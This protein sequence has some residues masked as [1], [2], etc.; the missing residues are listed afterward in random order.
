[1]ARLLILTVIILIGSLTSTAD[2]Q[3]EL[4]NSFFTGWK[5]SLDGVEYHKVGFSGKELR[6]A[7]DGNEAAQQ[8]LKEYRDD[9]V[10]ALWFGIP[11]LIIAT[12]SFI[13][14]V[15]GDEV[16]SPLGWR[17]AI[18]GL[19]GAATVYEHFASKHLKRAVAIYNGNTFGLDLNYYRPP[20]SVDGDLQF[21]VT[22]GF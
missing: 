18:L 14:D 11:G 10:R 12:V 22:V 7:M 6:E 2:A 21:C 16:E 1:M 3:I 9:K 5:Y 19:C 13:E 15:D 4:K 8:Q 17:M 20:V